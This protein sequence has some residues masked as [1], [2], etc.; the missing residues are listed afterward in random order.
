LVDTGA[1]RA[2]AAAAQ[3]RFEARLTKERQDARGAGK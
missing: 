3:P 2:Y 1:C